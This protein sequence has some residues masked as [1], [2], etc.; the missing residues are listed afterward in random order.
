MRKE[1]PRL[2]Q[3]FRVVRSA[4]DLLEDIALHPHSAP[5]EKEKKVQSPLKPEL[6]TVQREER[7]AYSIKE[8]RKLVGLST[9]TIYRDI[10]EG[11]LHTKKLGG[12]TLILAKDLDAWL[13]GAS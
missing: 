12:R 9:A 11:R 8:V 5:E 2:P 13:N 7:L 4:I 6:P 1:D 3:L 10:K